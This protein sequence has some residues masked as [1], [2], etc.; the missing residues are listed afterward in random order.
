MHRVQFDLYPDDP[1]KPVYRLSV[2]Q[3]LESQSN[4]DD[5]ANIPLVLARTSNYCETAETT[6]LMDACIK[7]LQSSVGITT[8]DQLS[9]YDIM[10]SSRD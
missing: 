6:R 4:G 3:G 9:Q 8:L 7:S 5:I 10:T 2:A 1:D